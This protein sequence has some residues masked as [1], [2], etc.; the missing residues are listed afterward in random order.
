MADGSAPIIPIKKGDIYSVTIDEALYQKGLSLCE[1]SLIGRLVLSKGDK[2]WRIEDL[3]T[4]L[5]GLWS[6]TAAW[7]LISLGRGYYNFQFD[8]TIDRVWGDSSAPRGLRDLS[9]KTLKAA[10]ACQ[11]Y[12]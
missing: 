11:S 1:D 4:R 8:S 5:N 9:D 7:K 12:Y 3:K 6:P 10:N 2:S